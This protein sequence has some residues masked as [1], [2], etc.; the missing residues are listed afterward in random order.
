MSDV[1]SSTSLST[2]QHNQDE[3][4][5]MNAEEEGKTSDVA[6]STPTLESGPTFHVNEK[7]LVT[8]SRQTEGAAESTNNELPS[9]YEAIIRKSGLRHVDPT[10]RKIMPERKNRGRRQHHQNHQDPSNGNGIKEWC[11]LVHFQGWNARHDRWMTETDVFHDTPINRKRV[12]R[13]N[14][15]K[16][17]R[18]PPKPK[19]EEKKKK[20]RGRQDGEDGGSVA[21]SYHKNLQLITKACELPFT[22]QTILVDDRDKITKK[23][24]P[25]PSFNNNDNSMDIQ[26]KGIKMLHVLPATMTIIDVMGQYICDKKRDDLEAFAREQE[27]QQEEKEKQQPPPMSGD[28]NVNNEDSHKAAESKDGNPNNDNKQQSVSSTISTKAILKLKK[29]KRK[30]FALSMIALVD[31]SLSL[32]LL[33][34]EERGQFATNMGE[35]NSSAQS[36]AVGGGEDGEDSGSGQEQ[37]NARKRPSEVYGAEH[38]LRFL[39]KLPF[40]LSQYDAKNIEAARNVGVDEEGDSDTYILASKEQ[41]QEFAH[42]LSELIVFLQKHLD[43][44]KGKYFAVSILAETDAPY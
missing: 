38:L 35:G 9:L 22:L 20:K 21:H 39:L 23:I 36:A 11:H 15:G 31:I 8:D 34:K 14:T 1:P 25:P 29:K 18:A 32:F 41:S 27:R 33:Y 43:C 19:E 16:V 5:P 2:A 4:I 6:C 37:E 42:H 7:V 44:F 12:M 24:Y 28:V 30:Q 10:S 13:G 26:S 17:A 3:V 40:I